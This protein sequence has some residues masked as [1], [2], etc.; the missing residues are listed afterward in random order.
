[1][2]VTEQRYYTPEEY[3][4]LETVAELRSEYYQGQIFPMPGGT[5]NHNRIAGNFYA[6]LNFA[7]KKQPFD[8]FM[9]DMRLWIPKTRL[10][11]YPDVMVV[12]GK[13]ELAPGR[14]DTITNPVMIAEVLSPSTEEYDKVGKFQLYR[15]IPTLREYILISQTEVYAEQYSKIEDNKWLFSEYEGDA[16]LTLASVPF[17]IPLPELYDKVEFKLETIT[18]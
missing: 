6:A 5:P 11:T 7:L 18:E 17:Q 4:E 2:Q 10:Y 15:S 1:M 12:A 16:V 3:L 13:L 9:N 8:A 14:K